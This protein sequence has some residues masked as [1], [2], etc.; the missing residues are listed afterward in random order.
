MDIDGEKVGLFVEYSEEDQ[1]NLVNPDILKRYSRGKRATECLVVANHPAE[2][3]R[4]FRKEW[5]GARVGGYREELKAL[6]IRMDEPIVE[7]PSCD[8]LHILQQ[9][10]GNERFICGEP[11][12]EGAMLCAV[13]GW[14]AFDECPVQIFYRKLFDLEKEGKVPINMVQGYKVIL[15]DDVIKQG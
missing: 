5:E 6:W 8:L 9:G 15:G 3:I 4:I 10:N 1:F 2:A 14:D 13:E 12:K 11:K 7:F